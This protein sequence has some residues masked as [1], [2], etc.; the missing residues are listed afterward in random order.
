HNI[1][2][3]ADRKAALAESKAFLDKYY[4]SNFSA[5][6]VEGFTTAGNS[7]E[8]IAELKSYFNAGVQHVTLRLTSWDQQTQLRRF[9]DEV[10]PAFA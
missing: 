1:N 7:K 4:T 2:I 5:A 3:Q 8:C 9:L 6:F 10:V